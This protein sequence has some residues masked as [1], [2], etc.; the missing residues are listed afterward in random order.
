MARGGF[1]NM[2]GNMAQ[3]MQRAQK[4]QQDM[5]KLQEELN[6]RTF[7]ASSGGGMVTATVYGTKL[8]ESI[9]IDPACIDP[10]DAEMLEDLIVSA[11]NAAVAQ[12]TETV[13]KEMSRVTGGMNIGF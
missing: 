6:A 4:M 8:V 13:E 3:L 9:K 12:A 11:V 2:G 7:T 10:D 1:P 5:A